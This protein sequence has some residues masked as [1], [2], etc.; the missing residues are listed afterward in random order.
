MH[1]NSLDRET[2]LEAGLIL[3][4]AGLVT[5]VGLLVGGRLAGGAQRR[6]RHMEAPPPRGSVPAERH[7]QLSRRMNGTG[8][9]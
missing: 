8:E 4:A 6:R 3:L 9:D 1:L 2:M 5:G 7:Q